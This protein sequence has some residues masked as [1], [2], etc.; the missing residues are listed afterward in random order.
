MPMHAGLRDKDFR[1]FVR[2]KQNVIVCGIRVFREFI[3]SQITSEMVTAAGG[4]VYRSTD[5]FILN[6]AAGNWEDLR[7]KSEF[8]E[9][10]CHRI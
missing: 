8:A 5:F 4:Y 2:G 10:A 3:W 6:I 7:A 9:F 1:C